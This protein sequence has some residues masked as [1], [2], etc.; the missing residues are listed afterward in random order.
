MVITFDDWHFQVDLE[1]TLAYANAIVADHCEC[2]YCR[3]YYATICSQYPLLASF[4]LQFGALVEGPDELM[5]FEPTFFEVTYCVC[6]SILQK[7]SVP[8]EID[9]LSVQP[10]HQEELDYETSCPSPCFALV[11]SNIVLPWVLE[12]DMNEVVSPANEPEYLQRMWNR[13]LQSASDTPI[14]S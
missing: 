14:C 9:G 11:I 12:E 10:L 13:L 3:N 5:P 8:I 7:G 2:G 1:G 4:L 6:G